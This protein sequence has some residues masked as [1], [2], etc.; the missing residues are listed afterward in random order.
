MPD[1]FDHQFDHEPDTYPHEQDHDDPAL[2]DEMGNDFDDFE[3]GGEDEDFGDFDDGF[4]EPLA[5]PEPEPDKREVPVISKSPFVSSNEYEVS[6]HWM[7]LSLSPFCC[8]NA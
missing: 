7:S 5:A 8:G 3:A 2:D 1:D 6:C 4:E